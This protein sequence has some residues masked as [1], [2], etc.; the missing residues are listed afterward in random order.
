MVARQ[1][2]RDMVMGGMMVLLY[3]AVD[4]LYVIKCSSLNTVSSMS[5]HAVAVDDYE[6]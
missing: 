4:I 5:I 6:H 3:V 1:L 2:L